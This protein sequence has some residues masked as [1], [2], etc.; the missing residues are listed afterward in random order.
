LQ[1]QR[2][3]RLTKRK[4][5]IKKTLPNNNDWGCVWCQIGAQGNSTGNRHVFIFK[6]CIWLLL[7]CALFSV[8][9]R[10][11]FS[12]GVVFPL[13]HFL[14]LWVTCSDFVV[15]CAA[16]ACAWFVGH[17]ATAKSSIG[18][19][20]R[21]SSS[22]ASSAVPFSLL[23]LLRFASVF[24]L[25]SALVPPSLEQPA[26]PLQTLRSAGGIGARAALA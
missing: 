19:R 18:F 17:T 2:P 13:Q 6:R 8:D 22:F 4:P 11:Q 23:R 10:A 5:K 3:R 14:S 21:S 26:H 15:C 1:S 25:V 7:W 20:F 16:C 9:M 24:P 12:F